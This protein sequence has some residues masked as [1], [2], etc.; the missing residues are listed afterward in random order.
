MKDCVQESENRYETMKEYRV[1][2]LAKLPEIIRP[3]YRVIVVDEVANL[4]DNH[5]DIEK[6]LTLL[7]EK[8]RAS[9]I[10]LVLSTQ[11][12]MPQRLKAVCVVIYHRELR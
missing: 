3:R 1:T 8:A 9:G 12:L 10:H 4:C 7:A 2:K 11:R 6:Q 5:P